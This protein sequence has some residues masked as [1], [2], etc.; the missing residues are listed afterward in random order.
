MKYLKKNNRKKI[1]WSTFF[2]QFWLENW[3]F[4]DEMLKKFGLKYSDQ[5]FY[6]TSLDGRFRLKQ[7][8]NSKSFENSLYNKLYNKPLFDRL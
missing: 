4:D 8:K 7:A 5:S 1:V 3:D 2:V 6:R